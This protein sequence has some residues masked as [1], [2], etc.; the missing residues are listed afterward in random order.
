MTSSY[1]DFRDEKNALILL[2]IYLAPE[3]A[4]VSN[5]LA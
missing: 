1:D 5:E 3:H 4:I 2:F